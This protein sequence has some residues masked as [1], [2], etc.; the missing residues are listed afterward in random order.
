MVWGTS[1]AR[2]HAPSFEEEARQPPPPTAECARCESTVVL[3]PD[4]RLP[5]KWQIVD[6]EA[7]CGDCA[8]RQKVPPKPRPVPASQAPSRFRGCRISHEVASGLATIQI[9]AGT[10]PPE[11]RDDAVSFMLDA[12]AIA[13]LIIELGSLRDQVMKT[14]G[15]GTASAIGG[16]RG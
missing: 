9:R 15:P 11:G 8:P 13:E 3:M 1:M 14:G 4:R 10:V 2:R 12:H 7:V 16:A 6:G 5:A